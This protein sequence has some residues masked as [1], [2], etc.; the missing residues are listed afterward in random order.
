MEKCKYCGIELGFSKKP[1]TTFAC[2]GCKHKHYRE[3]GGDEARERR[4]QRYR[5]NY[6]PERQAAWFQKWKNE[7]PELYKARTRR[8]NR[9]HSGRL[10]KAKRRA[11]RSGRIW[12]IE[13][14]DFDKLLDS[15]SCYYCEG[16][17]NDTGCG[18][19]RKDSNLG[20]TLDNVVP[21]CGVCNKIK[22]NLLT[23]EEMKAAMSAVLKIRNKQP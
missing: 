9:S 10:Y 11:E 7:K 14:E 18:L 16:S 2:R 22:T 21:S 5:E 12:E 13:R 15:G 6:T 3:I 17:L 20:Y 1:R 23:C 19:D 8:S 4:N